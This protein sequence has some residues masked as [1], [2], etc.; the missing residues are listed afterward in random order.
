MKTH[1]RLFYL[2]LLLGAALPG[3]AQIN[4]S[5]DFEDSDGN[6]DGDFIQDF[7]SCTG[8]FALT[9]NFYI[10]DGDDEPTTAEAISPSIGNSNG[11]EVT[12]SYSYSLLD[13]DFWEGMPNSPSWGSYTLEYGASATGPWTVIETVSPANHVVSDNCATRTVT[14]TPPAGAVYLRFFATPG[15]VPGPDEYIDVLLN[16]DDITAV[17]E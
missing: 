11:F 17:Q 3:F 2:V 6:W 14:F 1:L 13:W 12:L 5:E 16:I 9:G 10:Y 4:Y 15:P 7:F 8:D